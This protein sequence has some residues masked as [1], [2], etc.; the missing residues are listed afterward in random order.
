MGNG[1]LDLPYE[2]ETNYDKWLRTEG[3]PVIRGYHIEDLNLVDLKPWARKGG[4]GT[5]INLEG[6]GGTNDAYVCEIAPGDALQPQKH[7]FE[8]LI[9]VLS[10][11]GATTIWNEGKPKQTFEWQE[12][13]LF[14][15]PLNVWHQHFNGQ[16][17]K[18]ARY[19]AV[20]SAPTVINLFHNL[21]F[22]FN[23]NFVFSDRYDAE[24]AFFSAKGKALPGRV[25]ESNFIPDVYRF[26]LIE[27]KERGAGGTNILFELADNT[28]CAHISEFPVGTY[29]KGHRHGPGAHIVVLGGKGYSWMWPEGEPRKKIDWHVA[30][31]FVPPDRWFHQ[32]F[33]VGREPAR[34]MALRWGSIKHRMG[35]TYGIAES[36]KE[37]GDQIE[38]ED[39]D[40]EIRDIY[41]AE[42][43]KVGLELRMPP[44]IR[45]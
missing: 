29:K 44:I 27:W 7:I 23:N 22:V 13:S 3:I 19:V 34:Y 17:D 16:G 12:G 41:V 45:G 39:E 30:S 1:T 5:F 42:L 11:R 2:E 15:I 9:F 4:R 18:P 10:G 26:E 8:E 21:D 28:M 24:E 25:W 14:S 36:V 40:R 32:H 20:T 37:G 31:M 6:A 33:N 38:Y 35:K 43:A